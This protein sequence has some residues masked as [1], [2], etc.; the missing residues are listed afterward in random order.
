M[1]RSAHKRRKLF[2]LCCGEINVLK[3]RDQVEI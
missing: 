2:A 1:D 3:G